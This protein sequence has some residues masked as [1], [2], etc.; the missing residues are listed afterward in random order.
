MYTIV[1]DQISEVIGKYR[2]KIN[3]LENDIVEIEQQEK[4]ESYLRATENQM[5]KAKKLLER[6]KNGIDDPKRSWFQTH[7]ERMQEKGTDEWCFFFFGF[8]EFTWR[9]HKL[10][11]VQRVLTK[12][13]PI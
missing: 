9:A 8:V 1:S 3:K 10:L 7:K 5:N 4:E 11:D 12:V 13:V 6:E 2:D